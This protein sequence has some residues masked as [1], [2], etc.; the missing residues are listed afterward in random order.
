[1]CTGAEARQQTQSSRFYDP[2]VD[3]AARRYFC[4]FRRH[5]HCDWGKVVSAL[6]QDGMTAPDGKPLDAT[7][8]SLMLS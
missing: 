7:R 6:E 1:M 8:V 4:T 3:A 2:A 5:G